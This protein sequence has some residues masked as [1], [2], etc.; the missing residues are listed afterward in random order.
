MPILRFSGGSAQPARPTT[1][2]PSFTMPSSGHL[3]ARHQPQQRGLAAAGRAEQ[4]EELA[5][6]DLEAHALDRA[7][8]AELLRHGLE[9]HARHGTTPSGRLRAKRLVS[10]ASTSVTTIEIVATAAAAG[11]LPS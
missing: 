8:L 2:S 9:R 5:V 4:R 1:A 10:M 11:E 6:G 3:E 7:G